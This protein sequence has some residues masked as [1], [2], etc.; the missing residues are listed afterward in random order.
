MSTVSLSISFTTSF[1]TCVS[2]TAHVI[3]IGWTS[4]RLSV[5][6]WYCVETAQSIV[7]LFT[8]WYSPMILV[9]W[10]PNFFPEFQWELL[11]GGVINARNRKKLQFRTNYLAIARK[12]L[13]ID[14]YMLLCISPAL[15]PLSIHVNL[16]RLS[17]RRTQGRPKYALGWFQKLTHVQLA[18]AI[19]IVWVV[20]GSAV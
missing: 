19:L 14:G 10:W 12:R 7:K 1:L 13:K 15:N 16:P 18:I 8:A 11:S 20:T 6:R 5:T 9:F 17:Q 4:V 3:D 2:H